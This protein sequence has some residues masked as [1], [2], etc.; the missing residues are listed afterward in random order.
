MKPRLKLIL[1]RLTI[2]ILLPVAISPPAN[3][4]AVPQFIIEAAINSEEVQAAKQELLIK[5]QIIS[6]AHTDYF[7]NVSANANRGWSRENQTTSASTPKTTEITNP[8]SYSINIDQNIWDGGKTKISKEI[9]K[10]NYEA[11]KYLYL[12]KIQNKIIN[13]VELNSKIINL[14]QRLY[15]LDQNIK[16][17]EYNLK[18]SRIRYKLGEISKTDVYKSEARISAVKSDSI[19]TQ[20]ELNVELENYKNEFDK[21]YTET[22]LIQP[23]KLENYTEAHTIKNNYELIAARFSEKALIQTYEKQ[24]KSNWPTITANAELKNSKEQINKQSENSEFVAQ[25]KFKIPLYDGGKNKS[26]T[27]QRKLEINK[28][29]KTYNLKIKK[30]KQTL[31]STHG[32]Y[33][34]ATQRSKSIRREIEFAQIALKATRKEVEVGT[35]SITDM[36]DSEKSL[37]DAKLKLLNEEEKIVLST[38]KNKSLVGG[39]LDQTS[40]TL[41]LTINR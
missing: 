19:G 23:L 30:I 38:Y 3:A 5:K 33:M 6:T 41:V 24:K 34:S 27:K 2:S 35:K 9:A 36:L 10:L 7:P 12:E 26:E 17:L 20:T 13:L 16:V 15:Y 4:E 21:P 40:K 14:E 11:E 28:Y 37:L 1:V 22:I 18:S 32:E 31:L 29:K 25:L 39:L 8:Q